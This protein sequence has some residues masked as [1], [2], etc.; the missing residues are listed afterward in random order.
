MCSQLRVLCH[1]QTLFTTSNL[2]LTK[3]SL[4]T[5]AGSN[6]LIAMREKNLA[7]E[8]HTGKYLLMNKI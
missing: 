3:T 5:V 2:F 8:C 6:I 7:E 1:C 4:M